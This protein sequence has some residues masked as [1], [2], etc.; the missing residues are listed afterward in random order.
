MR[1]KY[2][3]EFGVDGIFIFASAANKVESGFSRSIREEFKTLLGDDSA[4]VRFNANSIRNFWERLWSIIKGNVSE[5][6]NK[7]HH[8]QTAHSEKTA[9]EHYLS[10]NGTRQDRMQVPEI[11]SNRLLNQGSDEDVLE[12]QPRP[13]DPEALESDF[14]EEG[15]EE[16]A[17]EIPTLV[18]PQLVTRFNM[19]R[20]SLQNSTPYPFN[21][22]PVTS[23][24]PAH[25]PCP[26]PPSTLL[27]ELS[28]LPSKIPSAPQIR[29]RD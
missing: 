9:Q 26:H 8:A 6:V 16:A 4:K 29:K 7:A 14:E 23:A 3:E 21:D 20:D 1:V 11:Y 27:P 25:N 17:T 2:I 10:K 5:G 24:L 22:L 19:V 28:R 18:D 12:K 15:H 13:I